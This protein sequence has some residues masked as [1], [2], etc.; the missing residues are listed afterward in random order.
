MRIM[1]RG[2]AHALQSGWL[3]LPTDMGTRVIDIDT[4]VRIQSCSNYS[5]LFFN[6]GKTLVVAKILGWFDGQLPDSLFVRVH[7]SHLI[8]VRYV[9]EY[10]NRMTNRI[11]LHDN[12]AI[13]V[14]RRKKA[15]VMKV[16][17]SLQAA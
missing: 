15:T 2:A 3:K 5:K 14:S 6:N 7:R 9:Q 11:T 16:F 10:D 8:G 13:N 1:N 17:R 12:T 4:I